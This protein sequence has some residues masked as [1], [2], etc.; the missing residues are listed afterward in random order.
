V[1]AVVLTTAIA[2]ALY[3]RRWRLAA[4]MVVSPAVAVALVRLFKRLFDREKGGALAYPAIVCV[5][6]QLDMCQPAC[7]L[8]HS[9]S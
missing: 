6:V 9:E 2:V 8:R 4:A 5:A 3:R 7:D 1:L